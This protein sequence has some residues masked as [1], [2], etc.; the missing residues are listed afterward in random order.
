MV[1]QLADKQPVRKLC[2]L[3]NLTRSTYYYHAKPRP[4][5]TQRL[6][7]IAMIKEAFYLSKQSAGARTIASIVTDWRGKR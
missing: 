6:E 1:N 3:F 7:L 4:I 2:D 5:N